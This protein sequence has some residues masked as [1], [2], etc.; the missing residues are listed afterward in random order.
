MTA[1][2]ARRIGDALLQIGRETSTVDYADVREALR[3][4]NF[5]SDSA[6]L[7]LFNELASMGHDA[8]FAVGRACA[9]EA[10]T[11]RATVAAVK[12]AFGL[13]GLVFERDLKP[14]SFRA[15]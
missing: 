13:F 15:D 10:A 14:E 4:E 6:V 7:S 8:H 9:A 12:N 11:Q 2:S 3:A 1:A 5:K